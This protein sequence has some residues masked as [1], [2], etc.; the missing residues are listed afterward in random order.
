MIYYINPL[1]SE[2]D[3]EYLEE[4]INQKQKRKYVEIDYENNQLHFLI[5]L[6]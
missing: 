1:Q 2:N 3:A 4:T 6:I 5:K